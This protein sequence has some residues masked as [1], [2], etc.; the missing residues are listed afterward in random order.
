MVHSV[1]RVLISFK[2]TLMMCLLTHI[3]KLVSSIVPIIRII[4]IKTNSTQA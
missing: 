4:I 3:I 2:N 1:L